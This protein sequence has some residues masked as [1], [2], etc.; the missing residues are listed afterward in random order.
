MAL[1]GFDKKKKEEQPSACDC[2]GACN[3]VSTDNASEPN[4][5]AD[6]DVIRVLGSGCC[7][8]NDLEQS[9]KEALSEL[10]KNT[11][12]VHVTDFAEIASFGVMT[13][14]ALMVGNKVVSTGKVLKKA[15]AVK[16]LEKY[17]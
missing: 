15:E 1:F 16:L 17:I 2:G 3:A 12:I 11:P 7:K 5:A 6:G 14:P 9:V 8:C 10:G 13:T 4:V